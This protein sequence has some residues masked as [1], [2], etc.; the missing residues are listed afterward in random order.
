MGS[1]KRSWFTGLDIQQGMHFTVELV[2]D[3]ASGAA[4]HCLCF[5]GREVPRGGVLL[6]G[7][8]G[9]TLFPEHS[10]EE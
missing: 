3:W 1:W 10:T 5:Q 4:C 9:L 8:R 6:V 7:R 2:H